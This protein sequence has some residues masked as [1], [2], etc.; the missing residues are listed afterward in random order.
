M[1]QRRTGTRTDAF[2]GLLNAMANFN[3][4]RTLLVVSHSKF[5]QA[6]EALFLFLLY[7]IDNSSSIQ[8]NP[9]TH[10]SNFYPENLSNAS[11]EFPLT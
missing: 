10:F 3:H 4:K 9:P 11:R 6:M 1:G 5:C 8:K 7:F 2:S